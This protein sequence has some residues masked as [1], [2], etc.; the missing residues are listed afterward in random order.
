MPF[1]LCV[2]MSGVILRS[3]LT[4]TDT[5]NESKIFRVSVL[6]FFVSTYKWISR[7][8]KMLHLG[9]NKNIALV[10]YVFIHVW[11]CYVMVK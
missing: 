9:Y 4:K 7:V 3:L 11:E 8:N 5:K 2:N 10:T 6:V 1:P